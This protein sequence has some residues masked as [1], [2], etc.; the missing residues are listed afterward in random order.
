MYLSWPIKNMTDLVFVLF[1]MITHWVMST[2]SH[3][4][5]LQLACVTI[6]PLSSLKWRS[7]ALCQDLGQAESS[8]S[9]ISNDHLTD[10]W[11]ST[12][13]TQGFKLLCGLSKRLKAK[14]TPHFQLSQREEEIWVFWEKMVLETNQ[15][16]A[17][18]MK[19]G[20]RN[21]NFRASVGA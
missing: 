7:S 12:F 2:E 15:I 10:C 8:I 14:P 9:F 4:K 21:M 11:V 1:T 17:K 13:V 18:I 16:G 5:H 20:R 6:A 3:S 19:S